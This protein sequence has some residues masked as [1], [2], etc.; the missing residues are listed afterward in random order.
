MRLFDMSFLH[1]GL[2]L[3]SVLLV[4][5]VACA[6]VQAQPAEPP[7][8]SRPPAPSTGKNEKERGIEKDAPSREQTIYIPYT[9]LREVFE[10]ESRGVFLPYSEFQKLWDAAR[11]STVPTKKVP[12]NGPPVSALITEAENEAVVER[13]VVRVSAQLSIE[14]LK[15]GW[16]QVPLGLHGAAL[17][18]ATIDGQAARVL[19]DTSGGHQLLIQHTESQ[20]KSVRLELKYASAFQKSPGQNEVAFDAPQAPVNRW[21]IRVPQAGVKITVLPLIAATETNTE[22]DTSTSPDANPADAKPADAKPE[23]SVLLAFVGA[24]PQV[25]ILW[26]PKAEGATGLT[27]LATVQS[28]QEVFIA[29]G[30]VRTRVQFRYE[31]SRSSLQ[32]LFVEV[33]NDHKIVNVFDANLRKWEVTA[34]ENSQRIAIDL[35]EPAATTQNISIQLEKFVESSEITELQAPVIK[36][37]DVGRQQGIVVVHVDP[38]LRAEVT[39]RT[40][41]LQLDAAE[42]PEQMKPMAWTFAYRYAALPYDLGLSVI[43]IQPRIAVDEW[44]ECYVE[45]ELMAMDILAVFDIAEAGVFQLEFD[46]PDG[47]EVRHVRGQDLPGAVA[48]SVDAYHIEGTGPRH[49]IVNLSKKAIGKTCILLQLEKRLSIPDLLA[50]TGS[51]SNIPLGVPMARQENLTRVNGRLLLS[52]P[53]SLRVNPT[54]LNGLRA[55]S[56]S[57]AMAGSAS[58]RG[59]RFPATRPILSFAF[60]DQPAG[61]VLSAERRRPQVTVKQRLMTSVDSGVVR[62]QALL[63]YDILYSSVNELRLDVPSEIAADIR[64]DSANIRET[65]FQPQPDD[66]PDG[67]V[68]WSLKGQSELIGTQTVTL[69]WER[70]LEELAVGKNLDVAV[71]HLRPMAVDRA[72]G[73]IVVTKTETLDVQP[74]SNATGLRPIDPLHDVMPE[75]RVPNA[76]RAFEFHGDW[77]LHLNVTRYKLEEIKHTS[78]ERGLVRMV[79]TRSSEIGVQAMYRLRS[80]H[81]RLT[82]NLA[83]EVQFDT[84]PARINGQPIGLER[85]DKDEFYIPLA[86][87]DPNQSLVLEL[88]YTVKGSVRQLD[89]PQ[90][91]EDPAVQKVYLNLFV[92]NE[93]LLVASDGPW[94]EE[95]SWQNTNFFRWQPTPTR[96]DDELANWVTE[97]IS[98][99]SSPPFQKDGTL[100]SF[101]ALKPQGP[102]VGSLCVTTINDKVL[103]GSVF[104]VLIAIALLLLRR[105]LNTKILVIALLL[106]A[107]I[108][109]GVMVP[110]LA[111]QLMNLPTYA[112]LA[113][114]AVL[115]AGWYSSRGAARLKQWAVTPTF[116]PV[117]AAVVATP[118]AS[119]NH[120]STPAGGDQHE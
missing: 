78:I 17:Q 53:E 86:G 7:S 99:A 112:G 70:K 110:S 49:L 79:V 102:P 57:D 22:A 81:Q 89:L 39:S 101:S 1:F 91:P 73:Q 43:K 71:P 56:F 42:L 66:V 100:Y 30:T 45:P 51:T 3:G 2:R 59:G 105:S 94:T 19:T 28:T 37:L 74:A 47:V 118:S 61:L 29:D 12:D 23:E 116:N 117:E 62:F 15:Q 104:G 36:A 90:F 72:W 87:H 27:A 33:P 10:K 31:I 54:G 4:V 35:F 97:G 83:Q 50:P 44:V 84:Q 21:K 108:V 8:D 92:P 13:D 48:A 38:A 68:A 107:I 41:L 11:E 24:A 77:S 95:W 32:Q 63:I 106:T 25:R 55:I 34:K 119:M 88:R 65:A 64:N 113:V 9:K 80:V 96:S 69:S 111:Q 58:Q 5:L 16:L 76:A 60:N 103:S 6:I 20:P 26:T 98:I 109:C 75:A 67:Y 40:G 46:I 115:W 82:L 120:D 93:Q 114:I 85:G 52:A 18:S 14:L